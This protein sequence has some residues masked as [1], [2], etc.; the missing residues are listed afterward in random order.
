MARILRTAVTV[1][2][3]MSA[4]LVIDR[5]LGRTS[6]VSINSVDVR[7]RYDVNQH[8][9][10]NR[11]VDAFVRA[12]AARINS[13][14]DVIATDYPECPKSLLT[15]ITSFKPTMDKV[16]IY[17]R[18]IDN[19]SRLRPYVQPI[20]FKVAHEEASEQLLAEARSAGWIIEDVPELGVNSS[21]PVF[22]S[23]FIRAMQ[24]SLN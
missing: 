17:R 18:T 6:D 15:L 24:V 13:Y 14:S 8:V 23:L 10:D 16:D 9:R 21:L 11:D 22:R 12:G 1:F 20:L 3:I 2:I 7:Y 19:W 4:M 5:L